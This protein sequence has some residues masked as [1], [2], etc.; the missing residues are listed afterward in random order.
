MATKTIN[1]IL[2]SG[3]LPGGR[4]VIVD[5]QLEGGEALTLECHHEK[6]PLLAAAINDAGLVAERARKALPGESIS[7]VVPRFA[8]A[9]RAGTSADNLYIALAFQTDTGTPLE[10]AMPPE[11]A[12]E[13]IERLQY[14]LDQLGRRPPIVPS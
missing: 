1:K 13:T 10:I 3:A 2:R 12:R 4:A 8:M 11:L 7:T 6:L 9:V 14:E 5:L